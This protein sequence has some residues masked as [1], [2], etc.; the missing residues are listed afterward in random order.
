[1]GQHV[2]GPVS[3]AGAMEFATWTRNLIEELR[4]QM[5]AG[6]IREIPHF[7][8]L[9]A[10]YRKVLAAIDEAARA[11]PGDRIARVVT[12]M[13]LN[14]YRHLTNVGRAI[15]G[16][17]TILATRGVIDFTMSPAAAEAYEALNGAVFEE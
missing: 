7:E 1:V 5:A 14:E 2:F 9:I 8:E 10:G 3:T 13:S 11:A 15:E 4:S 17:V 12:P 6:E 16:H